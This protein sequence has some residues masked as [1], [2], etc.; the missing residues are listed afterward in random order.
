MK[1]DYFI[2]GRWR[3]REQVEHV[4]KSIRQKGKTAYCF[5]ENSYK[6]DDIHIETHDTA[7]VESFMSQLETTKDW[8]DNPTFRKIFEADMQALKSSDNLIL[9]LPG[10]LSCHMELGAAYGMGK[11][12]FGVGKPEK[13]ET[14]YLMFDAI[15][16]SVEALTESQIEVTV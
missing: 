9:V 2:A 15:Y 4:L 8:W 7:D 6:G 1:Y 3:N 13:H 16:P 14:L 12:C 11:K 10:G 5:V